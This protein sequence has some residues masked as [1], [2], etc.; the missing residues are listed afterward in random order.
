ML[1]GCAETAFE[2]PE[3]SPLRFIRRRDGHPG[4]NGQAAR[5]IEVD[6]GG[7]AASGLHNRR[8]QK[9]LPL[10][11]SGRI[12]N[13]AAEELDQ[14][15]RVRQLVS[16][17]STLLPVPPPLTPVSAGAD[18]R[19]LPFASAIPCCPLKTTLF[20]RIESPVPDWTSTPACTL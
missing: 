20:E 1:T 15:A 2:N 18:C 8:A 7:A 19:S 13:L 4:A 12:G 3:E 17:P 11:H 6:R 9:G 5:D 16:E 14:K 10:A